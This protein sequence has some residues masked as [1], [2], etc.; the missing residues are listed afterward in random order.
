MHFDANS[1]RTIILGAAG[2]LGYEFQKR[3]PLA[4]ALAR[5][6]ADLTD[7]Q[8]LADVLH[9]RR[10]ELVINCAA[11]NDV[12][13]AEQEVERS[14]EVNAFGVRHVAELCRE[15]NA[16]LI[17]F[18]TD[19]VFGQDADRTSPLSELAL[20]GPVNAYGNSKLAGEHFV[21]GACA[22]HLIVRTCGLYGRRSD[23]RPARNFVNSILD[24][25]RNRDEIRVV[26]D[27]FCTPSS[28]AD[29]ADSTLHVF[30]SRG[31]GT[32]HITN[33]GSCSWHGFAV[34]ALRLSGVVADVMP[35]CSSDWAAAA[36]RPRYSVLSADA[37]RA[38]RLPVIP[39]WKNALEAFIR[40]AQ[41]TS[42]E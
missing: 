36:R 10:P 20:P 9:E 22:D 40:E 11:W 28:A 41:R 26:S 35:I 7:A 19:A 5:S 27:Q 17:H 21:R 6:D 18:S 16:T 31:R 14:F 37:Y 38:A 3:L 15:L 42:V 39:C 33:S 24:Q 2:Q 34:A 13:R 30:R 1:A 4:T 29:V 32:F 23:D 25:A 8:Q 12:D